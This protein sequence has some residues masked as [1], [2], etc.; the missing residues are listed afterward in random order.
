MRQP[1]GSFPWPM[2]KAEDLVGLFLSI[3]NPNNIID[4]K[5]Q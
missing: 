1:Y 5:Y 4:Q 2:P 3:Y